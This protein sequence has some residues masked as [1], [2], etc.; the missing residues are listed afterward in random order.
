[1]PTD[2]T[3]AHLESTVLAIG[4]QGA[5][6]APRP[7]LDR[8]LFIIQATTGNNSNQIVNTPATDAKFKA[9]I[10]RRSFKCHSQV[11]HG[12]PSRPVV[13]RDRCHVVV[14]VVVVV[15]VRVVSSFLLPPPLLLLAP[16]TTTTAWRLRGLSSSPSTPS[17][18]SS[19]RRPS[20]LLLLPWLRQRRPARLIQRLELGAVRLVALPVVT[21]M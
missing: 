7:C 15:V 1:M 14:V 13:L 2:T 16:S 12:I 3:G 5:Q 8:A 18:C 11:H 19:P 17:C 21:L 4:S 9:K 20:T 6:T 10:E